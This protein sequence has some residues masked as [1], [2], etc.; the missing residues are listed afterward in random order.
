MSS[1][2]TPLWPNLS[3]MSRNAP[4]E[5]S[6]ALYSEIAHRLWQGGTPDSEML[7]GSEPSD[8][9]NQDFGFT[10][11]VTLDA[12]SR[13]FGWGVKELRYGFE[14]GPL[15]RAEV[16]RILEVADWAF[17]NWQKGEKVLIRCQAG[18]NRS[19]LI[20]AIVLMKDGMSAAKAIEMIRAK[21]KF[22]LSNSD[23]VKF[24]FE[25]GG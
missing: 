10:A 2:V 11:V 22:G 16:P 7:D 9:S 12:R 25:I 17:E 8:S 1:R 15:D 20:T 18:A 14:D 13:P 6:L 24:L 23:F 21:R 3:S 5:E 4:E 19:G